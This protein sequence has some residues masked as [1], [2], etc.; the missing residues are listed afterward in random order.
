MQCWLYHQTEI[1][2]IIELLS[3]SRSSWQVQWKNEMV[4]SKTLHYSCKNR[5]KNVFTRMKLFV[6][7]GQVQA[8]LLFICLY[9]WWLVSVSGCLF[10]NLL[11]SIYK[12]CLFVCDVVS[13][14]EMSFQSFWCRFNLCDVVS[15]FVTLF[16][17][18][19]KE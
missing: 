2:K 15:N 8:L 11:R 14:F 5:K 7:C 9:C 1:L 13:T 18:V 19:F 16:Q 17:H 10:V 3:G 12:C 6:C 4:Y